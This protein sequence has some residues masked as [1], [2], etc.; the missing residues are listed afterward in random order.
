[1]EAAYRFCRHTPGIGVVLTG[2]SS[3]AHL[4]DNL[5]SI[6]RGPLDTGILEKLETL[7][8]RVDC[9]SGQ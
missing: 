7:F 3:A 6:Q 9:V 4:K 8:G 5:A 1:M 2:T